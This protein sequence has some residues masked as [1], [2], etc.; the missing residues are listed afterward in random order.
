MFTEKLN[1]I[2]KEKGISAYKIAKDTEIS[3]GLMNKY[4]KCNR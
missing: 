4:K 1:Q 2:L 3:Q